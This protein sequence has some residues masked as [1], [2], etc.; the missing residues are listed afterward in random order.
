MEVALWGKVRRAE[1]YYGLFL[2]TES[3]FLVKSG[4][5]RGTYSITYKRCIPYEIKIFELS[6]DL[7]KNFFASTFLVKL[8]L[9]P[10]LWPRR[11]HNKPSR[12]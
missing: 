11:L 1:C 7:R 6:Q 4:E 9:S 10:F 8:A 2:N 12:F 5:I 3:F